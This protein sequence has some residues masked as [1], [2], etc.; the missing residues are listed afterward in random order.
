MQSFDLIDDRRP[1]LPVD[2]IFRYVQP[3]SLP[4][5]DLEL[6]SEAVFLSARAIEAARLAPTTSANVATPPTICAGSTES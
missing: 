6:Q 2:N 5:L 4:K 1:Q 3:N